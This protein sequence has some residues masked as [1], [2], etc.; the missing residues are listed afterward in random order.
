MF[1]NEPRDAHCCIRLD[2]WHRHPHPSRYAHNNLFPTG[3]TRAALHDETDR[4][5][6]FEILSCVI[7]FRSCSE[8]SDTSSAHLSTCISWLMTLPSLDSWAISLRSELTS[9]PW[10]PVRVT[11]LIRHYYVLPSTFILAPF[12]LFFFDWVTRCTPFGHYRPITQC[13]RSSILTLYL[14]SSDYLRM[15]S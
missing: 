14:H 11:N 12:S 3:V 1:S 6:H 15:D 13:R 4:R 5:C 10:L 9:L 7:F 2:V 8:M